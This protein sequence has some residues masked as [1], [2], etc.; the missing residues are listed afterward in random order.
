MWNEI[1][2]NCN[3]REYS[4]RR[5]MT[6][7]KTSSL[8]VS[9]LSN[10]VDYPNLNRIRADSTLGP[11]EFLNFQKSGSGQIDFFF[12]LFVEYIV[13]FKFWKELNVNGL[14]YSRFYIV[15]TVQTLSRI[16]LSPNAISPNFISPNCHFLK[17]FFP[18]NYSLNCRNE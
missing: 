5:E 4:L 12:Y 1:D 16:S 11:F 13:V 9:S 6:R 10:N 3:R 2:V 18:N 14:Q 8:E 17:S 15:C 7:R